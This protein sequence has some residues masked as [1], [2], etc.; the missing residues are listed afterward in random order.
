MAEQDHPWKVE[1]MPERFL[2]HYRAHQSILQRVG[3]TDMA[4]VMRPLIQQLRTRDNLLDPEVVSAA[5]S[6]TVNCQA[7]S[8]ILFANQF[9]NVEARFPHHLPGVDRA[10]TVPGSVIFF[11]L[12]GHSFQVT[13]YRLQDDTLLAGDLI[14]VDA[15]APLLVD[16]TK[17]LFCLDK[18]QRREN[19]VLSFNYPDPGKDVAVYCRHTLKKLSWFP[20]DQNVQ[21]MLVGLES[22]VAIDDPHILTIATELSRHPHLDVRRAAL[23]VLNR[24]R[25][26]RFMAGDKKVSGSEFNIS[27]KCGE[28]V[29][30]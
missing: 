15:H 4:S 29:S 24:H 8:V 26:D 18:Q 23:T 3:A 13:R 21:R 14:T 1:P 10:Y 2:T 22:M 6:A 9:G 11:A 25:N 17:E 27:V 5:I 30:A 19:V 16:G 7:A 12:P 28:E 20:L